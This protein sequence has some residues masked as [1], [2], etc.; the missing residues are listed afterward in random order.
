MS[1]IFRK[2]FDWEEDRKS[3]DSAEFFAHGHGGRRVV[4]KKLSWK[5]KL[6]KI[7]RIKK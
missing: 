4:L 5:G 1:L 2:T 7:F 3:F 6:R